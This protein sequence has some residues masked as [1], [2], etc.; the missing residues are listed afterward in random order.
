M[1]RAVYTVSP[2]PGGWSVRHDGVV[3]AAHEMLESA[4]EAACADAVVALKQGLDATV[5]VEQGHA[6]D[7]EVQGRA[8]GEALVRPEAARPHSD[9]T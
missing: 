8:W 3:G 2:A 7:V 5:T 1:A 6:R 4:F 9:R